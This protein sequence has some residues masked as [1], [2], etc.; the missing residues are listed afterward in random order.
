MAAGASLS[1]TV[2]VK[3][4]VA[5]FPAVS[6]AVAVTVVTPVLNTLPLGGEQTTLTLPLQLSLAVG[7]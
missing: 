7:A 2:T 4:L 6:V 3:V 1:L 5:V